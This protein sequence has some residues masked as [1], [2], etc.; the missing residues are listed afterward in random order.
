MHGRTSPPT[1][2][3]HM[4]VLK[5]KKAISIV[6][7]E[8]NLGRGFFL[9]TAAP[10]LNDK[11]EVDFIV[12]TIRD[13]TEYSEREMVL[14]LLR[15]V[16]EAVNQ[17]SP[18]EEVLQIAVDGV[19]RIFKYQACDIF[20]LEEGNTLRYVSLHIKPS[21]KSAVEKL[22]GQSVIGFKI[23]LFEGSS[24]RE[25]IDKGS[26]VVLEDM[27]R[28]FED[29]TDDRKLKKLAP[30]VAKIVGF[31]RAL[32]VPLVFN[33]KVI[34]VL[35]AAT[36]RE[37]TSKDLQTLQIFSSHLAGVVA[38]KN[39]EDFV[40]AS[41][42]RYRS[43]VESLTDAVI[44]ID[45]WS[46]IIL[47]NRAATG[48]FGYSEDEALGSSVE[49]IIPE[50]YKNRHRRGMERFLK[51]GKGRFMGKTVETFARRKDGEI[52]P[53][54]LSLSSSVS[55][56]GENAFTA[57]IR[58]ITE[59]KLAESV[60]HDRLE[61]LERWYNVVIEREL[62]MMELKKK[63]KRLEKKIQELEKSESA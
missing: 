45:K 22:I 39:M 34:G 20:L 42:K 24:F 25:V 7:E 5:R 35:G 17:G 56:D 19:A 18:L 32:R 29:F 21:I 27:V 40:K 10:V 50:R 16:N 47:W 13:V 57:V 51:T 14:K 15:D 43:L 9:F 38:R 12:H 11:G 63:I 59:R 54:E 60:I 31:K 61:E 62:K 26:P 8:P 48:V 36:N 6:N 1:T 46:R 52:I 2:C 3:P 37:I 49:L 33:D 30:A 28:L 41:E 53:V 23:P 44:S 55:P 58:D 4:K